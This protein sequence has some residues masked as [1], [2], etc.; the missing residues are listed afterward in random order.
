MS[1]DASCILNRL[2]SNVRFQARQNQSS[3]A[4]PFEGSVSIIRA[5]GE[6]VVDPRRTLFS[7]LLLY[8]PGSPAKEG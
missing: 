6:D 8:V 4:W 1:Y 7:L 5:L 3:A 2:K